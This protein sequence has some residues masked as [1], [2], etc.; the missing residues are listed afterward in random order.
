MLN[1]SLGVSWPFMFAQLI[2]FCL[3][4]FPILK[5]G[6]F[7]SLE[8]KFLRSLYILDFILLEDI[9]LVKIFS[10][11]PKLLV[12]VLSYRQC[13]LPIVEQTH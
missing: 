2:I 8:S 9:G 5:I 10:K 6:L 1:I 3:A 12:V 7:G 11:S 13:A 4:L